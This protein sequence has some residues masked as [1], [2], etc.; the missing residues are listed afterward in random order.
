MAT[1]SRTVKKK[2][3]R[4]KKR[5]TKRVVDT[6]A[7]I[8]TSSG[9]LPSKRRKLRSKKRQ[10][11]EVD[12]AYIS[13]KKGR[14]VNLGNYESARFDVSVMKP[15][16]IEDIEKTEAELDTLTMAMLDAELTAFNEG[17]NESSTA[18]VEEEWVDE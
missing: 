9:G 3:M 10:S 6:T 12:P 8:E 17:D 4:R 16:Y 11:F 15:C 13:V 5:P 14:T 1:T 2:T 18:M 7:S